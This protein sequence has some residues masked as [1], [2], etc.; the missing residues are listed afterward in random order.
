MHLFNFIRRSV[1]DDVKMDIHESRKRVC[2]TVSPSTTAT[3]MY[4]NVYTVK[5]ICYQLDS[6]R[7]NCKRLTR[8][9]RSETRTETHDARRA[10][11]TPDAG[12]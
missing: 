6:L 12:L 8:W 3:P 1:S 9:R 7:V 4:I 11:C 10:L 2:A 5:V